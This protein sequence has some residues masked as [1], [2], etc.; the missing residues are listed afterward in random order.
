M[1]PPSEK[2]FMRALQYSLIASRGG[3]MRARILQ[4]LLTKPQNPNELSLVLRVD[5]KTIIHHLDMLQKQNLL[6]KNGQ[7]YGSTYTPT[8]TTSQKEWFFHVVSKL[9][10]SL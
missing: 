9:G 8:L 4:A 10:E 7:G 1:L 5:Y 2:I 6:V 3:V